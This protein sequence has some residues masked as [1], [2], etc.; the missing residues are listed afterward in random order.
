MLFG[1]FFRGG[2]S[3]TGLPDDTVWLALSPT[4][5]G[6]LSVLSQLSRLERE[7]PRRTVGTAAPPGQRVAFAKRATLRVR[8]SAAS[9]TAGVRGVT[10][11]PST[12][13]PTLGDSALESSSSETAG[14]SPSDAGW[15][16]GMAVATAADGKPST[17]GTD[18]A[19][20]EAPG[21]AMQSTPAAQAAAVVAEVVA[22]AAFSGKTFIFCSYNTA[23]STLSR[24]SSGSVRGVSGTATA[25]DEGQAQVAGLSTSITSSAGMA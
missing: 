1:N 12:M 2:Y 13:K 21:V 10:D 17:A 9:S 16:S 7:R 8:G 19:A 23:P 22:A 4:R 11:T 3:P 18:A 14:A 15:G 24:F 25:E 5:W 20:D 6:A